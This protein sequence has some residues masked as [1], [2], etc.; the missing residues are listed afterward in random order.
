MKRESFSTFRS[1]GM[2]GVPSGIVTLADIDRADAAALKRLPA[3]FTV[4]RVLQRRRLGFEL[5]NGTLHADA[6]GLAS[7][8]LDS[9]WECTVAEIT[10]APNAICWQKQHGV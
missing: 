5:D 4:A 3:A 8:T 1:R 2:V 9:I 7:T 6:V 10:L